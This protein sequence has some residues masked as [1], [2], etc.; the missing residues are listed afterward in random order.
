MLFR[1][2]EPAALTE[3]ALDNLWETISS[4]RQVGGRVFIG[5]RGS[6]S[7]RPGWRLE[8]ELIDKSC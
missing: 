7:G 1:L 2:V 8:L 4:G 6:V 3:T 5:K